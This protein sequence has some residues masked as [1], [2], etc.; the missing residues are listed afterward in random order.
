M[1][2]ILY[3]TLGVADLNRATAF[4]DAVL[5]PLGHVRRADASE[6]W[7]GYG[8]DYDDGVSLWLCTPFNGAAPSVGNG[9]MVA[10]RAPDA[11]AVDAFHA[12]ALAQGGTDEGA[13][14]V[15]PH[16]GPHFYVAYVRDPDGNKLACV[17]HRYELKG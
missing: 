2:L 4:Y 17:F 8:P 12:A 14:G 9:T 16:Y 10:F 3:T 1:S 11:A 7:E 5:A 13:P 6:G 15:R